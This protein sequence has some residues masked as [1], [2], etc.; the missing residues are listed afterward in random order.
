[1]AS[2]LFLVTAPFRKQNNFCG[3]IYDSIPSRN[4]DEMQSTMFVNGMSIEKFA[5]T[6]D[7]LFSQ[8]A[9]SQPDSSLM[10]SQIA[11][12]K[13]YP[14]LTPRDG[15]WRIIVL[16][17]NS[18]HC[19]LLQTLVWNWPY[20]LRLLAVT[21]HDVYESPIHVQLLVS[22]GSLMVHA[23]TN[24]FPLTSGEV[25]NYFINWSKAS[26]HFSVAD[27]QA[28]NTVLLICW[29]CSKN[30]W[31]NLGWHTKEQAFVI[32]FWENPMCLNALLFRKSMHKELQFCSFKHSMLD[33]LEEPKLSALNLY[34]YMPVT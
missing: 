10:T 29:L 25:S 32:C 14:G 28:Q 13:I 26:F 6:R 7:A 15:W 34:V 19:L 3:K 23:C 16:F 27:I 22:A 20:G 8:G 5:A 4:I 12:P 17:Q 9:L 11:A 2:V 31:K 18:H 33:P 21:K 30:T 24:N 1:M